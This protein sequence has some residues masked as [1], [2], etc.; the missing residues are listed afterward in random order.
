VSV[1][2]RRALLVAALGFLQVRLAPPEVAP[3]RRWLDSWT[4]IG[5]VVTGMTRQGFD[6]DLMSCGPKRWQ[7]TFLA[8]NPQGGAPLA[9]GHAEQPLPWHAVQRAAWQALTKGGDG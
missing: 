8:A 5:A 6:A 3:L 4:G 1:D 7:A 9:H 2:R